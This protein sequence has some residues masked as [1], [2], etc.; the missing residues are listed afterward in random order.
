MNALKRP[1]SS[2]ESSPS[3][4]PKIA[5]PAHSRRRRPRHVPFYGVQRAIAVESSVKLT[6]NLLLAVIAVTAIAKLVPYH[7]ERQAR[8]GTL[9]ESLAQA[10]E[11]NAKLRSQFNRN[12]DPAQAS[13]IMQEQSGMGY[14]NQKKVIWTKSLD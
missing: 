12:F 14:P 8:L 5:R 13:Q 9:Q 7:Q 10:K 3:I 2:P 1:I 11:K 6:I 4:P